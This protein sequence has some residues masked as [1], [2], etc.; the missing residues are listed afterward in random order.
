MGM[1]VFYGK[2]LCLHLLLSDLVKFK[3]CKHEKLEVECEMVSESKMKPWLTVIR[4]KV[5]LLSHVAEIQR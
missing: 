4:K 5:I 3:K 2:D 1:H